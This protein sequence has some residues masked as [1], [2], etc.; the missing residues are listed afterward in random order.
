MNKNNKDYY[1]ILGVKKDSTS[2][3]IKKSYRNLALKYHP[4]RNPDNK[5]SENKFKEIS[6]AYEIL[7]DEDKRQNYDRGGIGFNG[8]NG[9]MGFSNIRQGNVF[10]GIFIENAFDIFSRSGRSVNQ[11]IKTVYRASLKDVIGG[12]KVVILLSRLIACDKCQGQA[13]DISKETCNS[14]NG[15]GHSSVRNGPFVMNSICNHCHGTGKKVSKCK[16]CDGGYSTVKE[17][18]EFTIPVGISVMSQLKLVGKGNEIYMG[19]IKSVGDAYI[20][21]DFPTSQNNVSMSLGNIHTSIYVPFNSIL[22]QDEVV[23]D[24]LGCKKVIV[25]LDSNNKS[26]HVYC[27]K[28]EGIDKTK[29]AYIKV[30]VDMPKNKLSKENS[31]KLNAVLK[32]IY[33]EST[34]T[35][36]ASSNTNIS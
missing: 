30:F 20:M 14:C 34:K 24:I 29:S 23:V 10:D 4:D 1:E 16:F 33:G 12:S 22:L 13:L 32:E 19:G 3:E 15:R 31:E 2:E 26:G 7:S 9:S 28:G 35:Y 25:K 6:E 36:D 17:K 18:L 11:N 5:E 8:F 21:I 27:I